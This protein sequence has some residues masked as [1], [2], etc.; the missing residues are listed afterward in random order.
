MAGAG[1]NRRRGRTGWK[2]FLRANR[3]VLRNWAFL[4][5]AGVLLVGAAAAGIRWL[6]RRHVE[7]LAALEQEGI[8][9]TWEKVSAVTGAG[10]YDSSSFVRT[11]DFMT[12]ADEQYVS[13]QG[14]D[15]SGYSGDVDWEKVKDAGVQ[16]AI[17]R[18]GYR[19]YT[20]GG[21]H[22]DSHLEANVEGCTAQELP[23]GFYFFSQAVNEEE[24]REEAGFCVERMQKWQAG[25]PVFYDPEDAPTDDARTAEL[26][27]EQI[28]K[29]AL[30]FMEVIREAGFEPG[31][32]ANQKWQNDVLDMSQFEEVPVWFAGF[33]D[34]PQTQY[35]FEYWQYDY[36]GHVDGMADGIWTD[37]DIRLVPV[38]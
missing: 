27:G 6:H 28:T 24:A 9:L 16:F 26:S 34:R 8:D 13:L 35:H 22:E 7:Q 23:Y 3:R 1:K 31:L 12:Y 30:A 36:Q 15:V 32:Y 4:L 19:G 29:N 5:L 17:I 18:L 2:R 38:R 33:T 20:E 21:I 14:I 25:L 11:G 37:M 10:A